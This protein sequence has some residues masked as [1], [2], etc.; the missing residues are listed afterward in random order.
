[1][2]VG[3]RPAAKAALPKVVPTAMRAGIS[4][5]IA[6]K[7]RLHARAVAVHH[8]ALA[9]VVGSLVGSPSSPQITPAA[10]QGGLLQLQRPFL[11]PRPVEKAPEAVVPQAAAGDAAPAPK[12]FLGI[13]LFTWAKVIP[14]G[15]M[16]FCILFN[17]TILRDTKVRQPTESHPFARHCSL[18]VPL[19]SPPRFY[20]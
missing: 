3:M 8:F 10:P 9:V 4:A 2:P 19:A 20:C 15:M 12:T 7:V 18:S 6:P 5:K 1:M 14:L 16:F 17:Y 11:A 13:E